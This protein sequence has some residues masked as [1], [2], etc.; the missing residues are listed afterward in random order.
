[1][2][3]KMTV[4]CI[5]LI[6]IAASKKKLVLAGLITFFVLLSSFTLVTTT[7]G[8]E[9]GANC[10]LCHDIDG[11]AGQGKLVNFT[12]MNSTN[13]LHKNLNSARNT[14]LPAAN[15]KCWAC[16]GDGSEPSSGHPENYKTPHTCV[17]CHITRHLPSLDNCDICHV[18]MP[19]LDRPITII[20]YVNQHYWNGTS[21]KTNAVTSCM[22]CHNKS[23][24]MLG[25]NLD[26]DGAGTVYGGVNGGNNSSSHY[27]LKRSDLRVGSN[28]NC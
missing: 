25:L 15:K 24:M 1:M 10:I 19:G 18:A 17:D 9:G 8:E 16:H 3:E 20:K 22:D 26:P 7:A 13:S 21:I 14:S 2:S 28:D 12:A 4:E 23:E 11:S 6:M 5:N 27:G